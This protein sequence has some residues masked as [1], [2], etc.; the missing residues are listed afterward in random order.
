[1]A[2]TTTVKAIA[3]LAGLTDSSVA[4]ATYS[5]LAASPTFSPVG[6]SYTAAQTVTL[7]STTAGATI[8]YTLDGTAPSES[9]GTVYT[10]PF[11]VA[12]TT[13]VKAIAYLAGL[14]DSPVASA[15]Y[16]ILAASPTFSPVGGSYTAA[17][18][19]TL[20]SATGGA[21]IRYTLD[22]TA[23]SKTV[24]TVYTAP[25]SVAGTT[26]VKAIAYL[27]GLTDSSVASATY[28]ILA[29]SPTF[30]PVGGS[31]TAAQTVTLSSIDGGSHDPV[32]ARRHRAERKRGHGLHGAIFGGGH[33]HGEGHRLP[34]WPDRQF[35]GERHLHHPGRIADLQP[36]GWELHLRADSDAE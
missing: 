35:G 14:T 18:T 28:S 5:I 24:G 3:Y 13:T 9:A 21:T 25:F 26:T 7:S 34:N 6:G 27:T 30:S 29:A 15:T 8:R 23:P 36:R 10:A 12:G 31:Y 20:S 16:T 4:S 17:Q 33:R 1:M 11:S 2:G 19:V 32:H 22:G